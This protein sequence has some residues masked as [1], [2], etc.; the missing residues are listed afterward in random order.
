M[1]HI[2]RR[3]A[4]CRRTIP[5][6][7]RA[8]PGCAGRDASWVARYR[9]PDGRERSKTFVRKT[10]AERFLASQE[11]KKAT[12]EWVDPDLSR[13]TLADFYGRWTRDAEEANDPAASTRAKYEGIWRLYLEPRLGTYRLGTITREDVRR[14]VKAVR[15]PWQAQ[16]TLKLLRLLLYRAM[17]SGAIGRNPAARIEPPDAPRTAVRVLRPQELAAVADALPDRWRAFVLLGAY[18][19]L[20]WSELVA[21][22]R[23]DLDLDA[24]T[25]EVDEKLVEVRGEWVWGEPKTAGSARTVHLPQL[26]VRPLAEHLLRFPPLHDQ[27]DYRLQGLM[28]YGEKG[29]PVRRHSFRRVWDRACRQTGIEPIRLEWLRHTG[30]SLAYAAS[31]DLKAVAERLGHT[32]VRMV[33]SVYV[34][35]YEETSREIAD[36]IDALVERA[37]R[38]RRGTDAGRS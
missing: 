32:S 2:Q 5:Q 27:E 3:C 22:R 15:S 4:N 10:D 21:L 8:C 24:R 18:S 33:D 36:A 6:G 31:H 11:T 29:G 28:F 17:D 7:T 13:E 26:L 20:R 19:S 37:S 1:A 35:L 38:G 12:G 16:E 30:A 9:G 34:R 25:V 14:T 23:D